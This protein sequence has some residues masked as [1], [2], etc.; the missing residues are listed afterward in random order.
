MLITLLVLIVTVTAVVTLLAIASSGPA[1]AARYCP[2]HETVVD[3]SDRC[4][5]R[6]DGRAV[7]SPRECQRECLIGAEAAVRAAVQEGLV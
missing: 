6:A 2:R 5:A 3:V 7:G 1:P 4:Y